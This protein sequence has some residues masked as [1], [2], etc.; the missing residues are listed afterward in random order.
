METDDEGNDWDASSC[1]DESS[2]QSIGVL[3]SRFDRPGSSRSAPGE[4]TY[5]TRGSR[6]AD[7][8]PTLS[9]KAL[10]PKKF[11]LEYN[12]TDTLLLEKAKA[13]VKQSLRKAR[14]KLFGFD[15]GQPINAGAAFASALSPDFLRSFHKY[16]ISGLPRDKSS[17]RALK[18]LPTWNFDDIAQFLRCEVQMRLFCTSSA[19]LR[20]FGVSEKEYEQFEVVRKALSKADKLGSESDY[21]EKNISHGSLP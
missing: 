18:H 13:E 3:V 17:R 5:C 20:D 9:T 12:P 19:N 4:W 8:F 1:S 7:V 6:G 11:K 16:L 2:K 10:D 14:L 21:T 15:A